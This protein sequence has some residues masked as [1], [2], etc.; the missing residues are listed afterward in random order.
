MPVATAQPTAAHSA[1]KPATGLASLTIQLTAARFRTREGEGLLYLAGI[2]AYTIAAAL[3]LTVAGGTWAFWNRSKHPTGLHAKVIAED[4]T[5]GSVLGF[6]VVLACIACALLIPATVNLA[7]GAAVLGARGRERRLAVLRLMGLSSGEVVKMSLLDATIQAIIGAVLGSVIYVATLPAWRNLAMQAMP[8]TFDEMLLPAWLF[9][10][11]LL[12]LLLVGLFAA[13]RGLRQVRISPLGVSRRA[14]KP[15]LSWVRAIVFVV[16]LA[17]SGQVA[18]SFNPRGDVGP[19]MMFAAAIVAVVLGINLVAPWILQV[20][21]KLW[22]KLPWPS[23]KWAARRVAADPRATWRRVSGVALLS[24]IGGFMALMPFQVDAQESDGAATRTFVEES[25][26]DFTKGVIITLAV[27]FVLTATS[28]L[29]T[30]ASATIE[31]AEQSQ[32]LR[33]MGAPSAFSLK[34]MWLE[35]FAPLALGVVL[36]AG[37]GMAMALPMYNFAM[38][39]GVNNDSG[40]LMI[41][42]VLIVGLLLAAASLLASHPLYHRLLAT[43]ERRND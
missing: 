3:A 16:L 42:T 11:V 7:A 39:M 26:L 22:A 1:H 12:A 13:W 10:T 15:A 41:G 4:P 28:M 30:Q 43:S 5:F 38:K 27:G 31:R 36:G 25:Q 6:Y 24:F 17:V 8:L 19:A 32:A 14:N 33:R 2:L 37:L 18:S 21:A 29:I 34:T 23:S 20:E 35:T 40:L 9:A